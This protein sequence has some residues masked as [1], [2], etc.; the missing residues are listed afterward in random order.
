MKAI[1]P[2]AA[3]WIEACDALSRTERLRRQIFN[4]LESAE[5]YACWEPPVDIFETASGLQVVALLP[6]V[7]PEQVDVSLDRDILTISGESPFP[8]PSHAR[9]RRLEIPY[10]SF[11]KVLQ[12][13]SDTYVVQGSEY[14]DGYLALK[15]VPKR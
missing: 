8:A 6:G 11:R 2:L 9:I 7:N 13:P 14:K 4:L 1:D 3:M 12:L 5:R 15:L 10:G